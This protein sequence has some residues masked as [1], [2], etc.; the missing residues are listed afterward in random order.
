MK[1]VINTA[2]AAYVSGIMA[3][4]KTPSPQTEE[5]SKKRV[6]VVPGEII[7]SGEDYLPSEGARREGNDIC[8]N[9][10]GLAEEAG[11]VI[12][13]IP[14]T[15]AFIPRRNNQV[16]G[17]IT[18]VTMNGWVVDI[19]WATNAFIPIDE[20][21]RFINKSEMDQFLAIGDTVSAKI[22][23][24]NQ[25][26]IDLTLKGPGLGKL[27]EGVTFKVAS[28]RIPRVIGREGSM[29]KLIK[30]HTQCDVAVGQNGV[31]WL[32]G[33]TIENELKA[34]KAIERITAKAYVEGLTEQMER[35]FQEQK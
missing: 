27:E 25:R 23:N 9:R 6:V 15:G 28:A 4:S 24:I 31:V 1:E 33:E 19:D 17:R 26:G 12:K 8:A 30:E 29:I 11:R 13:V 5:S 3:L 35:W 2:Y 10:F 21:P 7:V 16:I 22:W 18:N 14:L 32:R 34:R 20:S